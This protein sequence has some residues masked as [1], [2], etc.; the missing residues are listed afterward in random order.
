[1]GNPVL[2]FQALLAVL[3][4]FIPSSIFAQDEITI[5]E[6]SYYS[7]TQYLQIKTF[8]KSIVLRLK[9]DL[10][11]SIQAEQADG[12]YRRIRALEQDGQDSLF[13]L[14][15]SFLTKLPLVQLKLF[16]NGHA[17]EVK[18]DVEVD[19]CNRNAESYLLNDFLEKYREDENFDHKRI[20]YVYDFNNDM[21]K[22]GLYKIYKNQCGKDK[23]SLRFERVNINRETITPGKNLSFMV[24]N[25]N[26]N[27]YQVSVS[28]TLIEY[29]SD[30]SELFDYFFGMESA[31]LG[32]L[33]KVTDQAENS[34]SAN[35][36]LKKHF[37]NQGVVDKETSQ[38]IDD[39]NEFLEKYIDLENKIIQTFNPCSDFPECQNFDYKELVL[40]LN[41]IKLNSGN[42]S[43]K[44]EELTN[45]IKEQ[46]EKLEKINS[47]F[48]QLK[49]LVE[50][51]DV[52]EN[53]PGDAK[54]AKDKEFNENI[55]NIDML[56]RATKDFVLADV[57]QELNNN[58]TALDQLMNLKEAIIKLPSEEI[59]QK[60]VVLLNNLVRQ[61][62]I[63][64]N[65]NIS[66][67]GNTLKLRINIRSNDSITKKFGIPEYKNPP[68][69][70]QIP[71]IWKPFVSF[72]SG[73]FA[74]L[75]NN[76]LNKTYDWQNLTYNNTV[77]ENQYTLVESGYTTKPFGLAALGNLEIKAHRNFGFGL[78]TGIGMT[79]EQSPRF[80]YLVGGSLFFGDMRQFAVTGGLVVMP[81]DH[82][83][84]SFKTI[85]ENQVI[86]TEK[87]PVETYQEIKT[88]IFLSVSYT[89]FSN[90]KKSK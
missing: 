89:P 88:G 79:I 60:Q 53:L 48:I 16:K 5:S 10:C 49:A 23:G 68:I 13:L 54:K 14:N 76:L 51:N 6:S 26:R 45:E 72:S 20:I 47:Q 15:E 55:Y 70:L 31:F 59:I 12:S 11:D 61:N 18:I 25:I 77:V 75:G 67:K 35:K 40:T 39:I 71:I 33:S 66:L 52:I 81:V 73:V 27:I 37:S 29:T 63:Y 74:A 2:R 41:K 24:I 34:I 19:P 42:L 84:E 1:M 56:K 87:I 30:A 83:T 62:Q 57:K 21:T 38:L 32:K 44:I 86:Y 36:G 9:S 22:R 8:P 90:V 43:I 58:K 3:F 28:D 85:A 50:Q 82:I 65:D 69:E 78:S 46:Q 80:A 7:Y 4:F 17:K 64:L